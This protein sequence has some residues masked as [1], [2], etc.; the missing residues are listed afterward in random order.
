MAEYSAHNDSLPYVCSVQTAEGM[1]RIVTHDKAC[2]VFPSPHTSIMPPGMTRSE[3]VGS[4]LQWK[5]RDPAVLADLH[6]HIAQLVQQLGAT[7]MFEIGKSVKA[8]MMIYGPDISKTV[9]RAKDQGVDFP[10][11]P[12]VLENLRKFK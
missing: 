9:Q 3:Y 11:P 5:T 4:T 6:D 1:V 8:A 12:I 7:G 2:F 10:L